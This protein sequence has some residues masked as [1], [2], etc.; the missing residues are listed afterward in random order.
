M[1]KLTRTFKDYN[2][3]DRTEDFYFNLNKAEIA[4]M[5]LSEN[6]G[7]NN[8]IN[9]I[10][11]EQDSKKLVAIFKEIILK[12]YGVKSLDGR[13]FVKSEELTRK[14]TQTEAYSDL[15][16]EL[17]TDSKKA[18]EFVNGIIPSDVAEKMAKDENNTTSV[19]A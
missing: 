11:S 13:E 3:V 16:I 6:G 15:F 2:G 10:I 12:S 18:A 14:F 19:S 1:L 9:R 17:A 8:L 7:M 5:E 4:E